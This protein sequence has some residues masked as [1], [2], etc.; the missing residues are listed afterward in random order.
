MTTLAD[1]VTAIDGIE[2]RSAVDLLAL[3]RC[4]PGGETVT[5]TLSRQGDELDA[6]VQLDAS[7]S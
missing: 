7:P 3:V 5:L 4:R 2:V 6:E 1:V